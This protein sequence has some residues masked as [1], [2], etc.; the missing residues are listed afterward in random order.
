MQRAFDLIEQNNFMFYSLSVTIF[1]VVI[2]IFL[3][4]YLDML[5][6]ADRSR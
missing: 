5:N 4:M 1:V 6:A 3:G 2:L